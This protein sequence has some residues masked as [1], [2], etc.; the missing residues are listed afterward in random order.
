MVYI[1]WAAFSW[2]R[3]IY[4]NYCCVCQ[5]HLS[6]LLNCVVYYYFFCVEPNF[7]VRCVCLGLR[8]LG[9]RH[10]HICYVWFICCHCPDQAI[11]QSH[12]S[13]FYELRLN[14][15]SHYLIFCVDCVNSVLSAK[16]N[17]NIRNNKQ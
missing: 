2:S 17:N 1:K 7:F 3:S 8:E 11:Y 14:N 5:F 10:Q 15:N 16:K 6:L 13:Y 12:G 4:Q 9:V